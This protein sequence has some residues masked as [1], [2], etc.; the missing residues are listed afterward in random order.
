VQQGTDVIWW[1]PSTGDR[2]QLGSGTVL[3]TGFQSVLVLDTQERLTLID[4]NTQYAFA[5]DPPRGP[6]V[7]V[8]HASLSI[9]GSSVLFDA[10]DQLYR[11]GPIVDGT[12]VVGGGAYGHV[13]W[14]DRHVALVWWTQGAL[15]M[16]DVGSGA[17][18]R[19]ADIGVAVEA[20][21]ALGRDI[22]A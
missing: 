13:V 19:L 14:T 4:V 1:H 2:I 17:T 12:K 22:P 16:V 8:D 10:G 9:D 7:P 11:S 18:R 20:V 3:D 5:V 15:T 6:T 21:V